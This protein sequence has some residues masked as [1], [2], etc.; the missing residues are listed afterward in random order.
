V[1]SLYHKFFE[2]FKALFASLILPKVLLLLF[3]F[4]SPANL[5]HCIDLSFAWDANTEPDLAGYRIFYREKGQNYD[6][7]N[8]DWE[9]TQTSATLYNI[10]DNGT[11]YFVAR[12]YD[13]YD[14]MSEDS[15]ELRYENGI[16]TYSSGGGGGGCFIATAAYGSPIKHHVTLLRQFRDRFLL[17]HA[18]GR[19]FVHLY[20]T[21][22]PP[23]ANFISEHE[24]VRMVVRWSL[25]PLVGLSWSLLTFGFLPTILLLLIILT[26]ITLGLLSLT[27]VYHKASD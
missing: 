2:P 11:Y 16:L 10:D 6:Y 9:G 8:P 15:D 1:Y 4:L 22:S 20:Y 17:P 7:D 3:I 24:S 27:E 18:P 21:Y 14:N 5:A 12:A 26:I 13:I 25:I 23:I 19:T